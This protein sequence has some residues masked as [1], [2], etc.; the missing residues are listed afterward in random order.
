VLRQ[1]LDLTGRKQKGAKS[2]RRVRSFK[3]CTLHQ[4]LLGEVKDLERETGHV[5]LM[6]GKRKHIQRFKRK[7]PKEKSPLINLGVDRNNIQID[8]KEKMGRYRQDSS[9]SR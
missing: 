9:G 7:C 6:G 8:I 4:I 5:A 1:Y 2:D 3:T